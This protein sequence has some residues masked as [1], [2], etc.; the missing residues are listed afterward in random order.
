MLG[1]FSQGGSAGGRARRPL[2]KSV[3]SSGW[4]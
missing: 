1:Q 2:A 3:Q 4:T